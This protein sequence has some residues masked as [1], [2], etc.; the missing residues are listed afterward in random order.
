MLTATRR[1]IILTCALFLIFSSITVTNGARAQDAADRRNQYPIV[2]VHGFMGF[3]AGELLLPD[4]TPFMYWGYARKG[5]PNDI[6]KILSDYGYQA[7]ESCP[8]PVLDDRQRAIQIYAQL[9][10]TTA[11]FGAA[12]AEKFGYHRFGIA[13]RPIIADPETGQSLFCKPGSFAEKIHLLGHSQGTD[14]ARML[15]E[16][17]T[18]GDPVEVQYALKHHTTLS[19]LF[20]GGMEHCIESVTTLS[21]PQNGT[22]FTH[23]VT[24]LAPNVQQYFVSM[25]TLVTGMRFENYNFDMQHWGTVRWPNE[26]WSAYLTRVLQSNLWVTPAT[27]LYSLSP[28]GAKQQ[29]Q[30]VKAAPHTYYFSVA[31]GLT[32]AGGPRHY[33]V[34]DKSM[35]FG[36][37]A[38]AVLMGRLSYVNKDVAIT[39][40]WWPNDG[41]VNTVSQRSPNNGLFD[42][43]PA[44]DYT[45]RDATQLKTGTWYFL[46]QKDWDHGMIVGLGTPT[47]DLVEFY[48]GI[49]ELLGSLPPTVNAK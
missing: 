47:A 14:T 44:E 46:G 11:D 34:P 26:S 21:A 5:A 12:S 2:L 23:S 35:F 20:L 43:D 15:V 48:H 10:G 24:N 9:T 31:T 16:L 7:Y 45:P 22:S 1:K 18:R 36:L 30:W 17:M 8:S 4:R 25:A 28:E 38:E 13:Y 3:C 29:N 49:A 40:E 32:H 6:M 27:S 42:S 41:L 33:Q 19:P 37:K 39:P